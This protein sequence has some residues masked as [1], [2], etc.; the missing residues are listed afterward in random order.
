MTENQRA[1][2]DEL[3]LYRKLHDDLQMFRRHY[4]RAADDIG[5]PPTWPS[6]G[7]VPGVK[8]SKPVKDN[9]YTPK[10]ARDRD[11]NY[12]A[13]EERGT[14]DRKVAELHFIE[15]ADRREHLKHQMSAIDALMGRIL[16][17]INTWCDHEPAQVLTLRF[18]FF[19]AW[20]EVADELHVSK[21]TAL[22]RYVD[23]LTQYGEKL[24][25]FDTVWHSL[26]P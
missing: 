20:D 10:Y 13:F 21:S 3:S 23:G 15:F 19:K 6:V 17:R 5:P 7:V 1:A 12:Y 18:V 8:R 16:E 9:Y 4:D 22:R 25:L 26:T 24:T 2:L 11:P 14:A